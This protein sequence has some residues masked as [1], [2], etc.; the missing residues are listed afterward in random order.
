MYG[1]VNTS[2]EISDLAE[3]WGGARNKQHDWLQFR[4]LVP[5]NDIPN[6]NRLLCAHYLPADRVDSL[7]DMTDRR[8]S[9]NLDCLLRICQQWPS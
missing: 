8:K 1:P 4:L 9:E 5:R 7:V 6:Y 3:T 2:H